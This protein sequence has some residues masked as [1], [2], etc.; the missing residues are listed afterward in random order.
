MQPDTPDGQEVSRFHP[1]SSSFVSDIEAWRPAGLRHV[2]APHVDALGIESSWVAG[3]VPWP[4]SEEL[5]LSGA[6]QDGT[7]SGDADMTSTSGRPIEQAMESHLSLASLTPVLDGAS[8][9]EAQHSIEMEKL[10]SWRP[11]GLSPVKAP[12]PAV[13]PPVVEILCKQP[14]SARPELPPALVES[15]ASFRP[16]GLPPNRVQA[17]GDGSWTDSGRSAGCSPQAPHATDRTPDSAFEMPADAASWRPAGLKPIRIRRAALDETENTPTAPK[18]AGAGAR[19]AFPPCETDSPRA[20]STAGE[21][22]DS[23]SPT[24]IPD[25]AAWRPAGLS[26]LRLSSPMDECKSPSPRLNLSPQP[27][28]SPLP[29]P[30]TGSPRP[31]PR[32]IL[33]LERDLGPLSCLAA[34]GK[35]S[36]ASSGRSSP[37]TPRFKSIAQRK[38]LTIQSRLRKDDVDSN[39]DSENT[40]PGSVTPSV[41]PGASTPGS[42]APSPLAPSNRQRMGQAIRGWEKEAKKSGAAESTGKEE[43]SNTMQ[44]QL[45]SV[46][47]SKCR[48]SAVRCNHSVPPV[49]G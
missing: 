16:A 21:L 19:C 36:A 12:R 23:L 2:K 17:T 45:H 43:L 5:Q 29:S 3:G 49:Q 31:R 14:I 37:S 40:P 25:P 44:V 38:G 46:S 35:T 11:L 28:I 48:P 10:D 6:F 13:A 27:Q 32:D 7:E 8:P 1:L 33:R 9:A 42:A 18:A 41:T 20:P 4:Q 34:D 22:D 24:V 30:R 15:I 39:A 26:P 47:F